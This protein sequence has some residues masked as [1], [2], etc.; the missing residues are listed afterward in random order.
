[1]DVVD[2]PKPVQEILEGRAKVRTSG[3]VFYNPVQEFNRDLRWLNA[4][5]LIQ[6]KFD[7][8]F[9]YAALLQ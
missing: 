1:M 2:E 7:Q 4:L 6:L 8:K 5:N 3:K 9:L